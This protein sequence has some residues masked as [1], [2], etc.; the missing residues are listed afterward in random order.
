MN[1][2]LYLFKLSG[3]FISEHAVNGISSLICET[4]NHMCA[5]PS[6][7]INLSNEVS[8]EAGKN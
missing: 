6:E 2:K 4:V 1:N 5:V 3:L 7:Y 8:H